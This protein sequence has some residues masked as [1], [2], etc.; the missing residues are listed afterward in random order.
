M[1]IC[2]IC[3]E[4]PP[5]VYGGIGAVT[6]TLAEG[7]VSAGHSVHIIGLYDVKKAVHE[8]IKGVSVH[9]LA[10]PFSGSLAEAR[11]K[12]LIARH[13]ASLADKGLI[14]LVEAPEWRGDSALVSGK[15]PVIIRMHN[16]HVVKSRHNNSV[17]EKSIQFFENIALV[18]AQQLFAVSRFIAEENYRYF[19]L[20]R[21]TRKNA[22]I[23]VINNA[24]DTD[25]FKTEGTSRKENSILFVGSI[26]KVKGI[27][28]LLKAFE[29]IAQHRDVALNIAGQ[30]TLATNR[31]S[32]FQSILAEVSNQKKE[33]IIYHGRLS[34]E[35]LIQLYSEAAISVFP[36]LVEAFPT[37]VLEAMACSSPVILGNCGPHSEII[38]HG[39]N[40]LICDSSNPDD[41]AEKILSVLKNRSLGDYLGKNARQTVCE[42]FN[43]KD[44]IGKNIEIYTKILERN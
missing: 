19:P 41:I 34:S 40:G 3:N 9:R 15:I 28:N 16:S 42:K 2:F 10:D 43:Y 6:K 36:S 33:K 44:W 12:M 27:M 39:E 14:E 4:Y 25:Y 22:M 8:D 1:K 18:R 13:I 11:R 32:Y 38:N 23:K 30:D 24:I 17:I 31:T 7:L 29:I 5:G 37:V 21:M 26:K 20:L 35:Q